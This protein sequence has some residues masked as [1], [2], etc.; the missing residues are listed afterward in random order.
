MFDQQRL[1]IDTQIKELDRKAAELERQL[2][3]LTTTNAELSAKLEELTKLAAEIDELADRITDSA[4][5]PPSE[6]NAE[7]PP[8][9]VEQDRHRHGLSRGVD[10]G[11]CASSPASFAGGSSPA[12][13]T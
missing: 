8:A 5:K 12:L 4:Q 7:A 6:S 9:D 1:V 10:S 11:P 2:Q 3:E 13:R